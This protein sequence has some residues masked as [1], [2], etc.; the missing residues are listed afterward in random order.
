MGRKLRIAIFFIIIM[1][2]IA[3]LIIY[4]R[5]EQEPHINPEGFTGNTAGNLYNGGLFCEYDGRI[6]FSNMSDDGALYS[7][8]LDCNNVIKLHNDKIK[9][10]NVDDKYIYYS[11]I[12][13]TKENKNVNIFSYN[14]S[15]IYRINKKGDDLLT[16]EDRPAGLV[17]LYENTIFYQ[18]YDSTKG[19]FFYQVNTNGKNNKLLYEDALLPA[20]FYNNYMYYSGATV[21]HEIHSLNMD[22]LTMSSVYNG[23][24]YLPIANENGIY[25]I[26][27]DNNYSLYHISNTGDQNLLVDD[28]I[29][30]YNIS[31][32]GNTIYLQID[33]G[34]N[35]RIAKLDLRTM[36]L[37]TIRDGNFKEIN[38]TTNYVFFRDF[39]NASVYAYDINTGKLNTFHPPVIKD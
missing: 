37:E 17:S 24:T 12:N 15:G 16:L 39:N 19:L 11:R 18:H 4:F 13:H 10:I 23:N 20:S 5:K 26:S 3:G 38:I 21:D 8:D 7:M 31:P 9:Y 28:F 29:S 2:G 35:N 1:L 34:E 36:T 22:N 30:T 6:Y 14:N 25:Y 27:L 32:D 33:G